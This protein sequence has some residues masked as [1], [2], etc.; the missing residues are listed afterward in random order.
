MNEI[1]IPSIKMFAKLR[2]VIVLI[3]LSASTN[4]KPPVRRPEFVENIPTYPTTGNIILDSSRELV[5]TWY[6]IGCPP[7][8]VG[9]AKIIDP[10]VPTN[11]AAGRPPV[12]FKLLVVG[13]TVSLCK[14]PIQNLL[15]H[16]VVT[17]N[18]RFQ[19]VLNPA[20]SGGFSNWPWLLIGSDF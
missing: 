14:M 2:V 5:D 4:G 3:F 20:S 11:S 1:I 9:S 18:V 13:D 10:A 8:P 15:N 12:I 7:M 16:L 17:K 6:I 19:W